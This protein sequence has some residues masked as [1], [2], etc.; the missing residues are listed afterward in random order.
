M[1]SGRKRLQS[2]VQPYVYIVVRG[3]VRRVGVQSL[4]GNCIYSHAQSGLLCAGYVRDEHVKF[5]THVVF[6]RV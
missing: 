4:H 1:F 5:S 3:A 6:E 2:T